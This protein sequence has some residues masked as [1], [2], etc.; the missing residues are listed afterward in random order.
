[1]E[2]RLRISR[3]IPE[4]SETENRSINFQIDIMAIARLLISRKRWLFGMVGTVTILAVVTMLM[5]PNRYTS[6]A[7]ILPSG[8]S[9]GN[10]SALKAMV[11]L[12]AGIGMSEENSS[13]LYPLILSSN[14][15]RDAVIHKTYQF[16]FKGEPMSMTMGEYMG[17]TDPDKARKSLSGLTTISADSRSGE[18]VL[19]VETEYPELS[20]AVVQEYLDQLEKFNRF[21]RRS[22]ATENQ[23][24]L[25]K[26]LEDARKQLTS[27]ENALEDFRNTNANWSE[28]SSPE[29][30]TRNTRLMREVEIRNTAYLLLQEQFEMAKL[31]AQK[32]IPIVNLLDG[33][34]LPTLKSGP[35]RTITVL[36]AM[37]VSTIIMVVGIL[38]VDIGRQVWQGANRES[39]ARLREDVERSF[40][41]TVRWYERR[42]ENRK[43]DRVPTGT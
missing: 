9:T 11:G 41:R 20:Q 19:Q 13:A 32:D 26:Q 40:P 42:R 34:S 24:Y 16:R 3:T 6:K 23:H 37:I 27:A 18:I 30:M 28:F 1:M 5:T 25:S 29:V 14:L 38:A 21:K 36:T 31:E 39:V 33:P 12:G 4:S 15:V 43:G 2:N 8:K 17:R 10:L 35:M 7:V 22:S